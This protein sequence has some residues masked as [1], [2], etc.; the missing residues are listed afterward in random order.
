MAEVELPTSEAT[1][2]ELED[3]QPADSQSEPLL[4]LGEAGVTE[5][6]EQQQQE[7][8]NLVIDTNGPTGSIS[9]NEHFENVEAP[10]VANI[11]THMAP[12]KPR[13]DRILATV[14]KS[15]RPVSTTSAATKHFPD[16]LIPLDSS[17]DGDLTEYVTYVLAVFRH[18]PYIWL[19]P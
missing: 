8:A 17:T 5:E 6:G 1:L 12:S 19:M 14:Q 11:K 7:D 10:L 3:E 2:A 13:L 9:H 18:K 16:P 4:S 15:S